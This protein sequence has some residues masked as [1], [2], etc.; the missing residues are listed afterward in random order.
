MKKLIHADGYNY[1]FNMDTG[2]TFRFGNTF[3]EDPFMAP[4]PELADISITNRCDRGCDF[5]YR[6]AKP[7]GIFMSLDN[8]KKV[9]TELP[10]TFQLALGGGEPTLHPDF[11]EIL[12]TTRKDF[13]RIPNYTTNGQ[14]LTDD[15][16]EATKKYCGA[17]A[18]SFSLDDEWMEPTR[19]FIAAGVKTNVHFVVSNRTI[20]K[21]REILEDNVVQGINAI[22]FLLFKPIGRGL[23]DWE[24][25]ESS[26]HTEFFLK[27]AFSLKQ[28]VG[29]DSCFMRIIRNAEMRGWIKPNWVNLDSCESGRFSVFIDENLMVRPCSFCAG[30]KYA[31]SLIDKS[32][33]EIWYGSKFDEFRKCLREDKFI[34]GALE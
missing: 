30:D 18:V 15:I 11:I 29:F 6:D 8:Y 23:K 5:C 21:A 27:D 25:D 32:F 26:A 28:K 20:I 10:N 12:R 3:E 2:Q 4:V 17:V 7:N 13:D 31:E 14:H 19:R 24:L 9:L 33:E 1:I 34:C 16:I 22:V